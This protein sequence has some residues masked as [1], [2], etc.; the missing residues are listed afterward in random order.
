MTTIVKSSTLPTYPDEYVSRT[1][2]KII[3]TQG[4][5]EPILVLPDNSIHPYYRERYMAFRKIA[6]V[7]DI[8]I[9]YWEDLDKYE[10]QEYPIVSGLIL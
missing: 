3:K 10:K 5:I 7:D 1:M 8:I 9:C 4:L 6:K 2:I